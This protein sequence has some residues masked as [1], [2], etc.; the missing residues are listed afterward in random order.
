M[1]K[2]IK[3]ILIFVFFCFIYAADGRIKYPSK[4]SNK[5]IWKTPTAKIGDNPFPTNPLN[6]RGKGYLLQGKIKNAI[7]NYGS[8]INWD[9]HP[10]GLWGE[11]AYLPNIGFLA[12]VPG[13]KNTANFL[14][15]ENYSNENQIDYWISR[16]A[17]LDWNKYSPPIPKKPAKKPATVAVTA[18]IAKKNKI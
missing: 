5:V 9:H 15:S 18:I 3:S 17:Y 11:Y 1:R 16:E 7:T 6:D 14:W 13:N 4:K 2:L 8:F 12:G 10:A